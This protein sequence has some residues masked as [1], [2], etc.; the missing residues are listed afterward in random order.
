[1]YGEICMCA[2]FS[3]VARA[4]PHKQF[5]LFVFYDYCLTRWAPII[6]C[7]QPLPQMRHMGNTLSTP[8]SKQIWLQAH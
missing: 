3:A 6:L 2:V 5:I 1:M 8:H 7:I 4:L